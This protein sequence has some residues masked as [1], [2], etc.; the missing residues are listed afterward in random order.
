MVSY[1][2]KSIN[3]VFFN[4]P[5]HKINKIKRNDLKKLVNEDDISIEP[6]NISS[7][8]GNCLRYSFP[9][10]VSDIEKEKKLFVNIFY[11]HGKDDSILTC[12]PRILETGQTVLNYLYSFDLKREYEPHVKIILYEYP[13]YT[14]DEPGTTSEMN[15][16]IIDNWCQMVALD[17]ARHYN[18]T[19]KPT[20]DNV[21]NVLIGFSL[22]A[23]F[24]CR[25]SQHLRNT[26]HLVV[27]EAMFPSMYLLCKEEFKKYYYIPSLLW[28]TSTHEYF[29]NLKN[30]KNFRNDHKTHVS[31]IMGNYDEIINRNK[32]NKYYEELFIQGYINDLQ[33]E[34]YSH[35]EFL[36]SKH[37]MD[38][39]LKILNNIFN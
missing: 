34:P 4:P 18:N 14:N 20:S 2:T 30:I 7:F 29:D 32:Y 33:I 8:K 1:I 13:F 21:F 6:I 15:N 27:L 24:C 5:N 12:F 39:G 26:I 17:M 10:P 16:R 31:V 37:M 35:E 38:L 36:C 22:G 9:T 25:L 23:G 3:E 28:S 11:F 19:D